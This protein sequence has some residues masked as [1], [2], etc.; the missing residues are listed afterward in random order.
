MIKNRP[1]LESQFPHSEHALDMLDTESKC[2]DLKTLCYHMKNFPEKKSTVSYGK[3]SLYHGTYC[4]KTHQGCRRSN[5]G[6][7][8]PIQDSEHALD[9]LEAIKYLR[10]DADYYQ[11]RWLISAVSLPPCNK[12]RLE[13]ID[14]KI[15]RAEINFMATH[16]ASSD[17]H[18]LLHNT[19][20][21]ASASKKEK[22][23][24]LESTIFMPKS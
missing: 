10:I 12:I 15:A 24:Y 5:C 1:A 11:H 16:N 3:N 2:C 13:Q 20:Y 9:M 17:V 8:F 23:T 21:F 4:I 7:Q 19:R 14:A 18:L 6:I 22:S